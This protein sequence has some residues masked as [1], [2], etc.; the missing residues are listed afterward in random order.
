M[1]G[2]AKNTVVKLLCDLGAACEEYQ[3]ETLVGLNCKRVQ[4]DE[5]WSFCYAKKKNLPKHLK[6]KA[7]YGDVWT[8]TALDP[9]SKLMITWLVGERDGAYATEFMGDV[10]SRLRSRVQLTT[11]GHMAYLN[12]VEDAFGTEV[13]YAML[14]KIYGQPRETEH[15]YSPAVCV[16]CRRTAV[17]GDPDPAHVSTSYI[18]RSNL[19]LRMGSRRFTRLTN[20]FSKKVENLQAA[21][22][23]HMMH[24]NFARIHT[25]TRVSPAMAAGVTNHLWS[26]EEI[27]GLLD[28]N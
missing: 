27:V 23:L 14:V 16:G 10:A 13:D 19:T 6:N 17:M 26:I 7:G 18:E 3:R 8:W 25:T 5:I 28:S 11:D 1:T 20:A 9:D 2:A 4:C 21:V 12:A 22:A 24:Y 15:R